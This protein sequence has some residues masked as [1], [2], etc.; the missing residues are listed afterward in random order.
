M[1]HWL[2]MLLPKNEIAVGIAQK[3]EEAD[4]RVSNLKQQ[5]IAVQA[6][7]AELE[8]EARTMASDCFD[9]NEVERAVASNEAVLLSSCQS[10]AVILQSDLRRLFVE[11]SPFLGELAQPELDKATSIHDNVVRWLSRF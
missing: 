2:K 8:E 7:R 10:S 11:S 4:E 6:R 3:I 9:E 1:K 5:I